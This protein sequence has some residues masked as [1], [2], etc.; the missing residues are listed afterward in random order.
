MLNLSNEKYANDLITRLALENI[1]TEVNQ[2]NG[3]YEIHFGPMKDK[4][5]VTQLKTKLQ[6][7]ANGNPLIVYTDK[8]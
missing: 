3:R 5:E 7:M 2:R 1:N 4:R 6:K 8:N